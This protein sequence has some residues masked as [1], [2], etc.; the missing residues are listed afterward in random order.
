[1]KD[2]GCLARAMLSGNN[3]LIATNLRAWILR[4]S[5]AGIGEKLLASMIG[6]AG[7]VF[8]GGNKHPGRYHTPDGRAALAP[9]VAAGSDRV[10]LVGKCL[11]PHRDHGSHT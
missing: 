7:W 5:L 10:A 3:S 9:E 8:A 2:S 1:M 11:E 6:A 4:T